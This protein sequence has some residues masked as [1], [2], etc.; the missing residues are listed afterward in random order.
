M[1][2]FR[3]MCAAA[4]AVLEGGFRVGFELWILLFNIVL[5]SNTEGDWVESSVQVILRIILRHVSY[6]KEGSYIGNY[7]CCLVFAIVTL[8][9][10][11][12]LIRSDEI[13]RLLQIS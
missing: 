13:G 12:R 7:I 6:D 4:T 9:C 2:C 5:R 10:S 8:G 11:L 1:V 3:C